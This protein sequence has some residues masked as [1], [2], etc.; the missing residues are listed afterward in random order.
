MKKIGILTI[1]QSPRPDVVGE[2]LNVFGSDY[3]ILEKGA[4]DDYSVEELRKRNVSDGERI[5]VTKLVDGQEI[6]ISHD[7]V[8][9]NL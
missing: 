1:G 2:F 7:F 8:L 4:L 5:L 6:K 3:E 9:S